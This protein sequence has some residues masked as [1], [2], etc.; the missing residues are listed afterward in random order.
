MSIPEIAASQ[1]PTLD[2]QNPWPGLQAFTEHDQDFFFGRE[3]ELEELARLVRREVLTV[4]FGRS[5]LGKTS[6]LQAGLFPLLCGEQFLAVKLRL[7]FSQDASSLVSQIKALIREA[8]H[9]QAVEALEP[10]EEETLWEYFHRAQIWNEKNRLLTPLLVFDQFE[11]VFTLGRGDE[12][13]TPFLTEISDLIENRIPAP[14]R[15]R[16]EQGEDLPFSYDRQTFRVIL[17]LRE[18]FLPHLEDLRPLLPSL[19]K[20]HFR[21]NRMNGLQGLEAILKPGAN[22]VSQSVGIE[23]LRFIAGGREEK[24]ATAPVDLKDM[25]V[26]PALL[27]LF[28]RE[29]NEKRLAK[30]LTEITAELVEGERGKILSGFYERSLSDLP[31]PVRSFIEDRLL[32]SSGFRRGEALEDA[33]ALPGVMQGS[34][35]TLVNRR[36]LRVERRLGTYQVEL[37]HDVLTGVILESREQRRR[38]EH[39]RKIRRRFLSVAALLGVIA[40]LSSSFAYQENRHKQE[41]EDDR[42]RAEEVINFMLFDLRDELSKIG[43]IDLLGQTQ[44]HA[45]KYFENLP[46]QGQ[47]SDSERNRGVV[48]NNVGDVYMQQGKT[49]DALA[50]YKKSL[51]IFERLNRLEPDNTL[52]KRDLGVTHM[53]LMGALYVQGQHSEAIAQLRQSIRIADDLVKSNPSDMTSQQ[54]LQYRTA[55]LGTSLLKLGEYREGLAHLQRATDLAFQL[56]KMQPGKPE[57]LY[58]LAGCYLRQGEAERSH[59]RLGNSIESFRKALTIYSKFSEEQSQDLYIQQQLATNFL[60]LGS[61]FFAHGDVPEAV[62]S[63]KKALDYQRILYERSESSSPLLHGFI[64]MLDSFGEAQLIAGDL[65][66]SAQAVRIAL[67][68]GKELI[69]QDPNNLEWSLSHAVSHTLAG[70]IQ[71]ARGD[72]VGAVSHFR[73]S[74]KILEKLQQKSQVLINLSNWLSWTHLLLGNA[75]AHQGDQERAKIE[76]DR[77]FGLIEPIARRDRDADA[78]DNYVRVLIALGRLEEA[79][80]VCSTLR[81]REWNWRNLQDLCRSKGLDST[82]GRRVDSSSSIP[83]SGSRS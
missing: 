79:K 54:D 26:E 42:A 9:E 51:I 63:F 72:R 5:G 67:Q 61:S 74:I 15:D 18:D 59:G 65:D 14:V 11:E 82:A 38:R 69:K 66:E 13:V 24:T 34:L 55:Q 52:W 30:S 16:L 77:A 3:D 36:L 31:K 35:T 4:L 6:L 32:T 10:T 80:P 27:S 1:P 12:R 48:F 8:L 50:L 47:S 43:R 78:L 41:A 21:L 39:R 83:S 33:L 37:I 40:L 81:E 49:K 68:G 22:I 75:Y 25:V 64:Q 62:N 28:C 71:D 73:E 29:L 53:N 56:T 19:S 57:F 46:Q 44:E 70:E 2:A 23:I 58:S 60:F 7:D 17:S 45:L 76:W 20:S